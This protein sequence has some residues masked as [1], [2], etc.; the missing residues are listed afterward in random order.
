MA[1]M[2]TDFVC[3]QS[4]WCSN[5]QRIYPFFAEYIGLIKNRQAS[6]SNRFECLRCTLVGT[7]DI[8]LQIPNIF[9]DV[10]VG[11]EKGYK[12]RQFTERTLQLV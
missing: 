7:I 4:L 2:L 6:K 8:I 11:P 10:E 9:S 12:T 3:Y 5:G 1:K